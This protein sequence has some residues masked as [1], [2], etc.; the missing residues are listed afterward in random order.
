M[1]S[2]P[3]NLRA[4]LAGIALA[5]TCPATAPAQHEAVATE[6]LVRRADVVV[7]GRVTGVRS[8]W[9]SDRSRINSS[10]TV[11]VDQRI[12]GDQTGTTVV[13]TTPGGEVGGVG[14][15]YSHMPRFKADERVVVFAARDQGGQL[16]VVGADQGKVRVQRNE[17]TG[18]EMVSEQEPLVVYAA[19]LMSIVQAQKNEK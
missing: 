5:M 12:K 14:E 7:V 19:R 13:I 15:F 6:D 18:V 1:R 3:V 11:S 10:V 2:L 8:G 17:A 4:T 16:S 9:N